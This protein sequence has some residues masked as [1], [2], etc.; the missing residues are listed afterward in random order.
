MEP[1]QQ[2]LITSDAPGDLN[3]LISRLKPGS[4]TILTDSNT[5]IHCYPML[6]DAIPMHE[7]IEISPG[8][9]HKNLQGAAFVW[10]ELT[11]LQV[12]RKGLLIILGGGVAGDLGGFCAATYKRSI[13]FI[14]MP[15]KIGRAHV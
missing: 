10:H 6:R 1:I 5:R 13:P 9:E 12:T 2:C 11:R 8:E 15:T 4:V 14:L 7:V 3:R